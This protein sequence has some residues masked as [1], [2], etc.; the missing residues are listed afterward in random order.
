MPSM[1]PRWGIGG[2]LKRL[3]GQIIVGAASEP[4]RFAHWVPALVAIRRAARYVT[5]SRDAMGRYQFRN[6]RD[7]PET[8]TRV[9]SARLVAALA[10]HACYCR[11]RPGVRGARR[12]H[13]RAIPEGLYPAPRRARADSDRGEP[14]SGADRDGNALDG[15]HPQRRSVLLYYAALRTQ[16]CVHEPAGRR[17]ARDRDLFRQEPPGAA[18]SQ[19]RAAGRPDLRL[20][21]PHHADLG[22]GTHLSIAAVQAPEL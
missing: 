10:R 5:A 6:D 15:R 16:G 11:H 2:S 14:G 12:L 22:P 17:P 19:L 18:A 8:P 21:Q 4:Q 7:D 3:T 13:R 20:H 9:L 1:V